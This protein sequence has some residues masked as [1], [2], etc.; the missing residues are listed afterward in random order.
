MARKKSGSWLAEARDRMKRK[1][2]V[3][4]YGHHSVS[5]MKRDKAKGGKIGR[6]A[7]FALN[8]KR[9]AAKRKRRGG[10]S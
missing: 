5:Q 10:R 9:V 3:G 1:G 8:M 6:K 4:S 2:T 7:N